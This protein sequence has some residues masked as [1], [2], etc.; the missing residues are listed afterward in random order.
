MPEKIA[1]PAAYAASGGSIITGLF[2]FNEVLAAIGALCA[3]VTAGANI[4]FKWRFARDR[5]RATCEECPLYD[6]RKQNENR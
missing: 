3:V 2:T 5:E 1:T 6:M 4:Y